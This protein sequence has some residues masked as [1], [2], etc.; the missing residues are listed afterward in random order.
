M[1]PTTLAS[2]ITKQ[3]DGYVEAVHIVTV[4]DQTA[5]RYGAEHLDELF[6]R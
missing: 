3:R 1:N 2:A 5:L 4:P 6:S